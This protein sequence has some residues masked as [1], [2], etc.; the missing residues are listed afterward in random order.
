MHPA[1]G[2]SDAAGVKV[3]GR[4]H[5]DQHARLKVPPVARHETFL[6][7]RAEPDPDHIGTGAGEVDAERRDFL[8]MEFAK[9]RRGAADNFEAGQSLAE[10]FLPGALNSL[11]AF[12]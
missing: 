8:R 2:L 3:E 9:R 4:A 11:L 7:R 5:T 6:L 10:S 1:R 12:L